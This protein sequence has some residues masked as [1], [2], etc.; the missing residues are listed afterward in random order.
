MAGGKSRFAHLDGFFDRPRS[1]RL[2]SGLIARVGARDGGLLGLTASRPGEGVTTLAL[3]LGRHLHATFGA[4][5]LIV[6]ANFRR[7]GMARY[8]GLPAAPGLMQLLEDGDRALE[9][10]IRPH[11]AAD[12]SVLPAGG[13]HPNPLGL[14]VSDRF[15]RLLEMARRDYRFVVCDAAPP[16][17][18]AEAGELLKR[19]DRR[20]LVVRA[21]SARRDAVRAN[22]EGLKEQGVSFDGAVLNRA[23]VLFG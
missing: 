20:I 19:M 1:I 12:L 16:P 4:P 5:V 3:Y 10:C 15:V 7:P 9:D 2:L 17:G 22:L 11:G 6:E 18:N 21:G 13:T 14:V 8:C 23:G